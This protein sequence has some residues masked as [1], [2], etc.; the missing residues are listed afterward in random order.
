[1]TSDKFHKY[2]SIENHYQASFLAHCPKVNTIWC[3]T[4]KIHG[5]NF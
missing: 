1:M 2:A 5:S 4:E 3:V